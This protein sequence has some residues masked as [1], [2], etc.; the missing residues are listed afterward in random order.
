MQGGRRDENGITTDQGK[1]TGKRK[2]EKS[3]VQAV[4]AAGEPEG[5]TRKR[6]G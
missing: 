4:C 5:G 6:T 3:M 2:E 1:R